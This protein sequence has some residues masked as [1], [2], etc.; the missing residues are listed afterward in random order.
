LELNEGLESSHA[1]G[2][3]ADPFDDVCDH[4]LVEHLPTKRIVG[5]YRMQTG[6]NAAGQ[7]GYYCEQEFS[8]APFEPARREII[9]VGRACVDRQHRNLVVLGLLWK[10]IADYR[11]MGTAKVPSQPVEPPA[12]STQAPDPDVDVALE[13]CP[14]VLL[15]VLDTAGLPQAGVEVMVESIEHRIGHRMGTVGFTGLDAGYAQPDTWHYGVTD[16]SGVCSMPAQPLQ[17]AYR[18]ELAR[19][20]ALLLS[21]ELVNRFGRGHDEVITLQ[22]GPPQ[23]IR[24]RASTPEGLPVAGMELWLSQ[25]WEGGRTRFGNPDLPLARTTT[26]ADG[27]FSF[28][29]A[30]QPQT[31]WEWIVGPPYRSV[32]TLQVDPQ[33]AAPIT[34]RV[35]RGANRELLPLDITIWRGQYIGGRARA[36]EGPTPTKCGLLLRADDQSVVDHAW[37]KDDGSFLFGP[38]VPGTYSIEA[39]GNRQWISVT[40][41][42]VSTGDLDV[43]LPFVAA[44]GLSVAVRDASGK[45]RRNVQIDLWPHEE[46]ADFEAEPRSS[47]DRG[48]YEWE[49]DVLHGLGLAAGRWDVLVHC[50]GDK[51]MAA[52]TLELTAG[53]LRALELSLQ[54]AATLTL[55]NPKLGARVKLMLRADGGLIKRL[56]MAPGERQEHLLPAGRVSLL[57]DGANLSQQEWTLTAGEE[58]TFELP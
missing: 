14:H 40:S 29:M 7:R 3:D 10:G 44:A 1:T 21:D 2:L 20:G 26:G 51:S 45:L 17:H 8:F 50:Q 54:P 9:E 6:P 33:A 13:P 31:G 49:G 19:G 18:I 22:I 37:L 42:A 58:L 27:S 36:A 30:R 15:R 57:V 24:G 4:L 41:T 11:A 56:E 5:T 39:L 34:A 16:D 28:A 12:A 25:A 47:R 53:S 35:P 46:A 48:N 38:L 52:T 55:I 32:D 23:A 43:Q